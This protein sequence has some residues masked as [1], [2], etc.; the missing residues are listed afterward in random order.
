MIIDAH[1]HLVAPD[2]LYAHR[3]NLM[4]VGGQVG[5]TYR[6]PVSD[7]DLERSVASNI[8]IM[9]GVGTDVQVL[10][11]RPFLMIN[12]AARWPDIV[13]W[14]M[15]NN[16]TI[17]RA[18]KMFPKR[19]HGVGSLPQQVGRPV[20]SLFD[21][22]TRCTEQLGFV[23]VLLNPDPSEGHSTSPPLGDPYW[24]PLYERLCE[25]GLPAHIHSGGCTNCRETYDEHFVAEESLAITS[26][27]RANVFARFPELQLMISHGGGAIPYQVGRWR[28]HREQARSAGRIS[29]DAPTF[30]E[31]L[32]K[33]WF[34]TCLHNR[35]SLQLLFDTVGTDR[36]CFGTERPGSGGGIDPSNGRPYDDIKPTIESIKSL[37]SADLDG[38]FRINAQRLFKR[39]NN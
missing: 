9:D 35:L 31:V 29:P 23:G 21:E 17:A 2:S 8:A 18:V 6:A 13:S 32:R 5:E 28:S 10:S 1:A 4:A 26:I 11:P 39:L 3:S 33:F 38:I 15:D 16:D 19:F 20:S 34:D 30:D 25:L 22:I 12:G 36:C 14:T 7:K 37:N 24:Y 27:Y